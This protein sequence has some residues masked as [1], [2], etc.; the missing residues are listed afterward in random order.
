M[1]N[2]VEFLFENNEFPDMYNKVPGVFDDITED[3]AAVVDVEGKEADFRAELDEGIKSNE[4]NFN[5]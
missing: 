5:V 3:A 1:K 2:P 4:N